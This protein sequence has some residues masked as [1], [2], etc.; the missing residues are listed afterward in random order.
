MAQQ[1]QI[2]HSAGG[3]LFA[4][5]AAVDVF[6]LVTL[7]VACNSYAKHGLIMTR[8]LTATK[9]LKLAS[10]ATGK[11]YKRGQ[12]A[13]AAADLDAA[14]TAARAG[15]EVVGAPL[16]VTYTVVENAGYVGECDIQDGFK[17][18]REA[19][20][21]LRAHYDSD[22]IETLHVDVRADRSDGAKTYDETSW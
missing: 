6:R 10:D 17:T 15:V 22:E 5:R 7:K 21:Y 9:L 11:T 18:E 2:V 14:I 12:H 4:G 3:T 1:A 19:W 13:Q 20:D 16:T 8:G